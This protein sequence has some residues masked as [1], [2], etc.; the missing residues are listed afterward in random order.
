MNPDTIVAH[1]T[2]PGV[3]ALALIRMSGPDARRIARQLSSDLPDD[4]PAGRYLSWL[5]DPVRDESLDQA[6]VHVFEAPDSYTGEDSVEFS[7]HGSELIP[8]WL[9]EACVAA[10]A[11]LAEPG[12]F[13]RRAYLNGKMD[14]VQ[15]ES[16]I[17]LIESRAPAQH[18]SALTLLN[19]SLSRRLAEL[20]ED[21]LGLEAALVHHLDFPEEDDPPVPVKEVARRGSV[22]AEALAALLRSAPEGEL[23]RTGAFA[24]F[25]GRPNS[26]KSSLFNALIGRDRAI[27]TDIAGTT[28]DA[29]E[30]EVSLAGFPFVLVD[31]AGLRHSTD[32][33]ERLG[34]EVAE[35]YLDEAHLVVFCSEGAADT[36]LLRVVQ[37]RTQAPVVVARTKSDLTSEGVRTAGVESLRTAASGGIHAPPVLGPSIEIAVSAVT[38][39]GLD[40]L[41]REMA[42][43]V[44][45]Q[46]SVET[47][48]TVLIRRRQTEGVRRAHSEVVRFVEALKE[49]VPAEMASTHLRP[50]ESALE[51]LMGVISQDDVLDRV[52]RDFCVGK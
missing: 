33:V 2:P 41:R 9:V 27:V 3:S 45:R 21:L 25:A 7:T 50:A 28:R 38:G 17:D 5:R 44:F 12:E 31:T 20:R 14:L 8:A 13:T 42:A 6:L 4:L 36:E 30:A 49:G 18:R 40:Q 52:F 22:I 1:A 35:R 32:T 11:R 37:E 24:V 23:L 46:L 19:R 48:G 47:R 10:G 39:E 34:V 51:E 43:N 15:A 26:G 29:I 16:V